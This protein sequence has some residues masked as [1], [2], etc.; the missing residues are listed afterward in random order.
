M[1]ILAENGTVLDAIHP[2]RPSPGLGIAKR[3]DA[4]RPDCRDHCILVREVRIE[5]APQWGRERRVGLRTIMH[6]RVREPCAQLV[7]VAH[8]LHGP[9][10]LAVPAPRVM[11]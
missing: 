2:S 10:G 1:L 7:D 6:R 11:L 9:E 3:A 4:E 5:C 8:A